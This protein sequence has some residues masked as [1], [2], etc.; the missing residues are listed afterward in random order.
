VQDF[1][2]LKQVVH[3]EI[4]GFKIFCIQRDVLLKDNILLLFQMNFDLKR[5]LPCSERTVE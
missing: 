5:N 1:R 4:R 3:I 2:K